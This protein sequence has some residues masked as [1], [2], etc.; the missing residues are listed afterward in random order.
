MALD[1][2]PFTCADCPGIAGTTRD[3]GSRDSGWTGDSGHAT[4]GD[5][6]GQTKKKKTDNQNGALRY[7]APLGRADSLKMIDR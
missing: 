1:V 5:L 4:R 7:V 6:R 2:D 3:P